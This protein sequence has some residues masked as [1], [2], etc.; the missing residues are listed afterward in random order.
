MLLFRLKRY[1]IIKITINNTPKI[2]L[3]N[4]GY[5]RFQKGLYDCKYCP[6]KPFK[7]ISKNVG[8]HLCSRITDILFVYNNNKCQYAHKTKHYKLNTHNF[9]YNITNELSKNSV[10]KYSLNIFDLANTNYITYEYKFEDYNTKKEFVFRD[11]T[12]Y[13]IITTIRKHNDFSQ[14]GVR[15]KLDCLC[16]I[17][18]LKH[19]WWAKYKYY[20]NGEKQITAI[21]YRDWIANFDGCGSGYKNKFY[22]DKDGNMKKYSNILQKYYVRM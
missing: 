22:Y 14:S 8:L 4:N 2:N 5:V 11:Q 10:K 3:V 15:F 7:I 18:M 9:Y 21:E 19:K 6:K 12:L 1:I 20:T 17:K 13:E 16:Y